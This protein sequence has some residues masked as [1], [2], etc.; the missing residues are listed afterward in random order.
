MHTK[1]ESG[2]LQVSDLV[3]HRI[4]IP[5]LSFPSEDVITAAFEAV[6][7][8]NTRLNR[9]TGRVT[10]FS[11]TLIASNQVI[12]VLLRKADRMCIPHGTTN[13]IFFL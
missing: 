12:D 2:T 5:S 11:S 4:T 13:T 10:A 7:L 9:T 1:P 6:E 8:R 3:I